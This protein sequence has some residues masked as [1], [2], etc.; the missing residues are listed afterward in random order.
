MKRRLAEDYTKIIVYRKDLYLNKK[1]RSI[2]L[3]YRPWGRIAFAEVYN[4][5]R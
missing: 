5:I 1:E 2:I 3:R 4:I